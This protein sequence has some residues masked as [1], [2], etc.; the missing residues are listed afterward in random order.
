MN[1][2]LKKKISLTAMAVSAG[3]VLGMTSTLAADLGGNCC[4]DL[5]ERV[6][7]LEATTVKKGTRKT[8]VELWGLVNQALTG[9]GDGSRS[10]VE[11]GAGNHSLQTRF[12]IRGSAKIGAEYSAGYSLVFDIADNARTSR[13]SQAFD[14]GGSAINQGRGG[15]YGTRL[16]DANWWLESSRIGRLTFGRI[17]NEA[18]TGSPDLAGIQHAVSDSAGCNGGGLRFRR[19]DGTLGNAGQSLGGYTDGGNSGSGC[20][21]PWANRIQ[22]IKYTSP[23]LAGFQFVAAYG[24]NLKKETSPVDTAL[25]FSNSANF[26]LEAG[27]GIRYAAEFNGVRVA[28]NAGYVL[29]DLGEQ[30]NFYTDGASPATGTVNF[31]S[32]RTRLYNIGLGLLHVPTGLFAQGEWSRLGVQQQFYNTTTTTDLTPSR[33]ATRWHITAGVG[34]NWFG[35]GQTTLYGEYMESSNFYYAYNPLTAA[36]LGAVTSA[37]VVTAGTGA[38]ITVSGDKVSTWGIGFNQAID[39]AAMDLY[40]NYRNHK[41]SDPNLTAAQN[42]TKA[43][44]VVTAGARIRF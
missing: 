1:E 43:L 19:G 14:T 25:N 33:D 6:A 20:A 21:G 44:D 2:G 22:G 41:L 32:G 16:R 11:L 28:A 35:V 27:V 17:V 40:V 4:A 38:G 3:M 15:D 9:W 23:T 30:T 7:E 12:G 8:S 37:G 5:E 13:N 31:L 34:R 18:A 36:G 26:G 24:P 42:G 39:A 29:D 10:N